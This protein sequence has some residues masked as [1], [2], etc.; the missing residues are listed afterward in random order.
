MNP[1]K[2]ILSYHNDPAVKAFHVN[3]AKRH[4]EADMLQAGT[5]GKGEGAKFRGS[6]VSCM[7]HEINPEANG[8]WHA[9]IAEHAGWPVW[10]VHLSDI[11]FES[12]PQGK[13]ER[14]HVDLREA[15]PVGANLEPVRHELAIH[16]LDR[17]I[18]MQNRSVG[19]HGEA[20]DGAITQVLNAMHQVRD[21][22]NSARSARSAAWAMARSASESAARS[23][24]QTAAQLM[25][26][27]TTQ[28]AAE[29]AARSAAWASAA[30]AWSAAGPELSVATAA[31]SVKFAARSVLESELVVESAAR[32]EVSEAYEKEANDLLQLLSEAQP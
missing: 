29:S 27:L 9:I 15:I 19:K 5:Y 17:L 26:P 18:E 2:I 1:E 23:V 8:D 16:R 22:H 14:F 10:L 30:A 6:S 4:Y 24:A 31:R 21:C 11:L 7:A 12:L 13:R 3:R 32:P 28:S 20:V 25:V